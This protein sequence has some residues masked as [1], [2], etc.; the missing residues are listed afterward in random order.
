MAI[1][2]VEPSREG[3]KTRKVFGQKPNCSQMKPPNLENWSSGELSKNVNFNY[4]R[5]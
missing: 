2:V 4:S 1:P 3:H 5:F